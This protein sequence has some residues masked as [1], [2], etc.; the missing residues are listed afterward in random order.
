MPNVTLIT[1]GPRQGLLGASDASARTLTL[2]VRSC[3]DEPAV[4]LAVVWGYEAGQFIRT[5]TWDSATRS[6]WS[7]LRGTS[8]L[9]SDAQFKQDAAAVFA[10][11]QTGTTKYWQ[12]PVAPP[13]L[14]RLPQLVPFLKFS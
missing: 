2:Y 9:V 7:Q 3:A 1:Q 6:R 5:E 10:L 4:Q 11:W 8:A 13:S 12:S 14:S